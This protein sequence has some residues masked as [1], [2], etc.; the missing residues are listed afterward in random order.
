MKKTKVRVAFNRSLKDGLNYDGYSTDVE[1]IACFNDKKHKC[2]SLVHIPTGLLL[3]NFKT[4]KECGEFVGEIG[5]L[6]WDAAW[7]QNRGPWIKA[8]VKYLQNLV[9]ERNA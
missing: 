5:H 8:R 7:E 4:R 3:G 9:E 2:W 6:H 1:H